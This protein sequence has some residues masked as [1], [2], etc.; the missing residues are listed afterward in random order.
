MLEGLGLTVLLLS[1]PVSLVLPGYSIPICKRFQT[2]RS[3]ARM[4][5]EDTQ[6]FSDCANTRVCNCEHLRHHRVLPACFMEKDRPS[7]GQ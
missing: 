7:E 3:R 5:C 1:F 4:T 6:P 2:V